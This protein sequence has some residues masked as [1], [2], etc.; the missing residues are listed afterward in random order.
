MVNQFL[1]KKRYLEKR[2]DYVRLRIATLKPAQDDMLEKICQ[3]IN[4]LK[5]PAY[6]KNS[7]LAYI[8]ANSA[9]G[10]LFNIDVANV[11]GRT[12][13]ELILMEE[14]LDLKDRE[15][16]CLVFGEEQLS[17]FVDPLSGA[18]FQVEMERF[19]SDDNT[20]FL[21][22]VFEPLADRRSSNPSA[23]HLSQIL[24][25]NVLETLDVGVFVYDKHNRLVWMNQKSRN[26]YEPMV[27][28]LEPGVLLSEII[29]RLYD[30]QAISGVAKAGSQAERQEWIEARLAKHSVPHF[31]SIDQYSDGRWIQTIN[32]RLENGTLIGL[33]IDVTEMKQREL[34]LEKHVNEVE[35]YRTLLDQLPVAAFVRAQDHRI[36]FANIAYSQICGVK[37]E[38]LVGTTET[39]LFG[40]E[41]EKLREA[42]RLTLE[43]GVLI[44]EEQELTIPNGSIISVLTRAGRVT[45]ENGQH[46]LVGS[47]TDVGI[48]RSR[49]RQ[50][51]E[52]NERAEGMARDFENIISNMDV[53]LLVLDRDLTIELI[54][55]A[56]KR[57][58]AQK[59]KDGPGNLVGKS[60]RQALEINQANGLYNLKD[61]DFEAYYQG[62]I[63]E[64]RSCQIHP[65]EHSLNN[66]TIFVCSS[67]ALSGG[68]FLLCYVDI[69]R[70]KTLDH[71]LQRAHGD[72]ERALNLVRDATD[73]MPQ[74]LM[75][76]EGDSIAFANEVLSNLLDV[77]KHLLA[78]GS[79]RKDFFH[80]IAGQSHGGEK[81]S[82]FEQQFAEQHVGLDRMFTTRDNRWVQL[83][84]RPGGNNRIVML[85]TDRTD[86]IHREA[87]LKKLVARAE[88][89]DRAKTEFLANMSHEIR[90]PMNGILG[91]AELLA[92]TH[93]DTRQKTFIDII[94]KSG[95][96]LL[97]IINDILDF[98]K[99]DA[100]Q[101]ELRQAAFDPGEAIE[102]I[103][104]LLS[105]RA[106]EKDIELIIRRD[107]SAAETVI[108]DAG[109]FRQ[110]AT[111]LIGNAL[112]FTERGHVLV[113]VGPF[114]GPD[115]QSG[116]QLTVADTGIGI[117][118]DKISS[119]FDKFSQVDGSST[120]RHE[121]TGLGLAITVG[122]VKLHGGTIDVK[123]EAGK[124][125]VFTVSLPMASTNARTK[126]RPMPIHIE[127]ARVLV[128]DDNAVNR[129]ILAEQLLDWKFD[130]VAVES[131][132]IGFQMLEAVLAAGLKVD[133]IILDYQMPDQNGA[134]VAR[135]I[136]SD[137]RFAN[138]AII[139]L[140]SM[141]IATDKRKFA[142]LDVDAHLMKPARS[143][144]L[145]ETLIDV[146][147]ASRIRVG[148]S[149]MPAAPAKQSFV[150][151]IE[152]APMTDR[153]GPLDVLPLD[154]LIAEDN[155][156]NQIVFRQILEGTGIRFKIVDNGLLAVEAWLSERP[157][158]IL[159]DV[160]M[161]V[162]NGLDATRR[163]RQ[164]E[165]A[166]QSHS[167]IIGVTAHALES[168]REMCL[169]AGMDDYLS[170]PISPERLEE[171]IRQWMD[172]G[173]RQRM[174]A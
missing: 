83:Q 32:K 87:E 39:E 25:E 90:T 47:M 34:L 56:Q 164:L 8:A 23:S 156:V 20:R 3:K 105:T 81:G 171:K 161:P 37:L 116:I 73:T 5:Q 46:F 169:A 91:M 168:D 36:Q 24:A 107:A 109:R 4:A 157:S 119:I 54:N 152:A 67:I 2:T 62:S 158:I 63:Q 38:N 150:D 100:G 18:R 72:V 88:N 160:S 110:I 53:G 1:W 131:G 65:N 41:G 130:A 159:M 96:A 68:K 139:F 33:R 15:R 134:D 143:S 115:G 48:M 51:T 138:I 94:V 89:A 59:G 29:A 102:D 111:N 127:G 12:T 137:P 154:V 64:I 80:L 114:M 70:L 14:R 165:M 78:P 92:K 118:A 120:R 30:R 172:A 163:I 7:A 124:G 21:Y 153:A 128:I 77:P 136:R 35:L 22:G 148:N 133:A 174:N 10:R 155:E 125:S 11:P 28:T 99:L 74:G 129:Q 9:Y 55:D 66:G 101:L 108:G 144:L 170:K 112:K 135:R 167:P 173:Y 26:F 104:S 84:S 19:V 13:Q 149:R 140:T 6:I 145:R 42:N 17:T 151:K 141:D 106:G 98:S 121:G 117:P 86:V 58:W 95:N 113:S 122:L 52:A 27:G 147:R 132:A 82:T 69:T 60:F 126:T 123:S 31:A 85:F 93:L 40:Q 142:D 57:I 49:E 45:T 79:S 97:T 75:V 166:N 16:Q 162:M 43:N 103:A 61:D 146:V 50:L 76:M 71:E 44:E